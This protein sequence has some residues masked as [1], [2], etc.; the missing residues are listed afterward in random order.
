[1]KEISSC[2]CL[3]T[4]DV[5]YP[6]APFFIH[7]SPEV[8]REEIVTHLVYANNETQQYGLYV[9]YNLAWAPHHLGQWPIANLRPDQQEQMPMEETGNFFIMIAALAQKMNDIAYLAPWNLLDSWAQYLNASLPDPQ[10]QLCTDD[11]EGPS[12]HNVN[13]AAKGILGLGAYSLLLRQKGDTSKADTVLNQ[14]KVFV[15]SWLTMANDGD[16]YRLQYNLAGTWSLKYN[17]LFQKVLGLDL[18]P[19]SVFD[20]EL[21]YYASTKLNTYGVPLD[22]RAT[23]TKSDWEMWVAA[24]GTQDQFNTLVN[25]LYNFAHT[26]PSRVPFTDWYDTKSDVR[27]GFQ[28][29]PVMGGLYARLLLT[30]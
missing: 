25:A 6:A 13:L 27:Q 4:V 20:K 7:F 21:A 28:A 12:P 8:L 19:Q 2:G 3:Q 18:F 10:D 1:M 26:S 11:F 5:I 16:H 24:M 30:K 17:L 22:N 23:F 29:R 15:Q 14:A 9:P